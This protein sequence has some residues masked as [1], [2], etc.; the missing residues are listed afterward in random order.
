MK[1]L[2]TKSHVTLLQAEKSQ[3]SFPG[4]SSRCIVPQ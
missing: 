3:N 2:G 1:F 4:I